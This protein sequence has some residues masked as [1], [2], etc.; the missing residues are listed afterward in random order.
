MAGQRIVLTL[1]QAWP[2]L[3]E[4]QKIS[5]ADQVVQVHKQLWSNF[6][7]TTIQTVDQGPCYP[8]LLFLD[9]KL[10]ELFL[11]NQELWDALAVV[12]NNLPQAVFNNVRKHFPKSELTHCDL[13]LSN[14]MIW[15]GE[16]VGILDWEYATYLPVWY[17]YI[18]VSFV[19]TAKDVE[20]KN[21]LWEHFGVHR[22][23]YDNARALW[24]DLTSL[25]QYPNLDEKGKEALER[26]T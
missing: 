11:S 10:Y 18:S 15:D 23:A 4:D 6:T 21:V 17:E 12:Y 2:P 26:L 16:M 13:N 19:F 24:K 8:G 14:I 7:S 22:D 5:I 20:W 3:S 9:M 1:E 25:K